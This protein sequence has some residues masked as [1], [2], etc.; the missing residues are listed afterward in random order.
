MISKTHT[1]PLRVLLVAAGASQVSAVESLLSQLKPAGIVLTCPE[2]TDAPADYLAHP[3]DVVLV[4]GPDSECRDVLD[5]VLALARR[6][7]AFLYAGHLAS[8][9][10]ELDWGGAITHDGLVESTWSHEPEGDLV[11]KLRVIQASKQAWI[12]FSELAAQQLAMLEHLSDGALV[13]NAANRVLHVNHVAERMLGLDRTDLLGK[14]VEALYSLSPDAVNFGDLPPM[15][16]PGM[17]D[18]SLILVRGARPDVAEE[19]APSIFQDSLT[20]LPTHALLMDRMAKAIQLSARYSRRLGVLKVAVDENKLLALSAERGSAVIGQ[21]A[22]EIAMRLMSAVRVEDSVSRECGT[23]FT[24]LLLEMGSQEDV[25]AIASRIHSIC[26]APVYFEDGHSEVLP[27]NIGVACYPEHGKVAQDLLARAHTALERAE[28]MH[29]EHGRIEMYTV[30]RRD[31]AD[32]QF[33]ERKVLLALANQELVM[34]YQPK[35]DIRTQAVLGVEAL[36]RWN[37]DGIIRGPALVLQVAKDLNLIPKITR[38][39]LSEGVRQAAVWHRAG[40]DLPVAVNVPPADFTPE[41][42]RNIER[43]L[44]EHSLPANLLELEVTETAMGSGNMD[45][46]KVMR[47][48][49]SLGVRLHIDDFGTGY[50]SIERLKSLPVATVKIDRSFIQS[51]Q[52]AEIIDGELRAS[53]LAKPDIAVLQ[54]VISLAEELQLKTVVEGIETEPQLAVMTHLGVQV[55]QGFYAAKAMP[56]DE[57]IQWRAEWHARHGCGPLKIAQAA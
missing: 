19:D 44:A 1:A 41:L 9:T 11:A 8:N 23:D 37:D 15:H 27:I 17:P 7:G 38:W 31:E 46:R 57:L 47:D 30:E 55:W 45:A 52:D 33:L 56:A 5:D 13:I 2:L 50:S 42:R 26:R 49:A 34:Y 40:I 35:M 16:I 28:L 10:V 4:T 20:G 32:K 29:Q 3:V 18:C 36:M 53:A 54:A 12:N 51:T 25:Q 39:A 6:K 14:D 43:L 21:V 48:I 22:R 24:A